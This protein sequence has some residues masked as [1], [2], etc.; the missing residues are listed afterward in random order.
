MYYC[1]NRKKIAIYMILY[2]AICAAVM[3]LA[4]FFQY[5]AY[6]KNY[7]EAIAKMCAIVKE[8]YPDVDSNRIVGMLND[9]EHDE[10]AELLKSGEKL[11]LKYGIDMENDS[12]II[13]NDKKMHAFILIDVI[14]GLFAAG[15][16]IVCIFMQNR[17]YTRQIRQTTEYLKRINDGN[18]I[19]D[20][21]DSKEGAI[22]ILK[23][24]LYKTAITM[25]EAAEN[26]KKD[27]LLLKDSLSDISHQ[28]KTP[29]TSL[30]I[31]LENLEDNPQLEETAKNRILRRAKKDVGNISHMVQS[32]LKL[33][34][35]DADVVEF[36]KKN[37][38][39]ADIV[40][41]SVD[42]VEALSDL[43]NIQIE[44]LPDSDS[45]AQ[46]CC[47]AYWQTQAVTNIVKNAVEHAA[48]TV[49]IGYYQ[50]EMYQ[51]IVVVNDGD[52]ISNADK[53]KIFKRFYRGQ[54]SS[55]DSIGIG[56]ALSEAIIKHDNGYILVDNVSDEKKECSG[57]R[58]VVRY[59]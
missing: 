35:L 51:E 28:L 55:A 54:N 2:T 7:N 46:I 56:L 58:F 38:K 14:L 30:S 25:R 31:N 12:A 5:R 42:S 18:Y 26:A 21:S 39:L 17:Y 20:M 33:S 23:S 24:E 11:L 13:S 44:I 1:E 52:G 6:T 16:F 50:Y 15:G 29:L 53:E 49:S 32:I 3:I 48:K 22:S 36:D 40:E 41:K 43:R 19:L 45:D 8:Q 27:K 59:C 37:T 10:K 57:T 47:D 34:R 4:V 9:R